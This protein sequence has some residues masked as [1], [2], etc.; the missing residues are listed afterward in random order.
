MS[1]LKVRR[2]KQIE[3]LIRESNIIV[4]GGDSESS[5][6]AGTDDALKAFDSYLDRFIDRAIDPE[7]FK[8][9][10]V[11]NGQRIVLAYLEYCKKRLARITEQLTD[12]IQ[13]GTVSA[14]EI[15][16]LSDRKRNLVK[17]ISVLDDIYSALRQRED[18]EVQTLADEVNL[19]I[20]EVHQLIF[21]SYLQLMEAAGKKNLENLQR[22]Q[23]SEDP[24]EKAE[25]AQDIVVSWNT[26]DEVSADMP[27][28][29][30]EDLDSLR[31]QTYSNIETAIGPER[32]EEIKKGSG[33]NR[34]EV[35]LL[36]RIVQLGYR[37]FTTEEELEAEFSDVRSKINALHGSDSKHVESSPETIKYMTD[38]VNE[39]YSVAKRKLSD[40]SIELNKAKGIRYDFNVKLKLHEVVDLP[41][42]GA[43]IADASKIMKLRKAMSSLLDL[44]LGGQPDAPM[45][46]AGQAWANFGKRLTTIYSKTL[47]TTA[48]AVGKALKGREGEIKGDA[49]SRMFIPS[50][51]TILKEP[52]AQSATFED[53]VAPG[54]SAQVPGSIGGMGNPAAPTPTSIGSGD[55]FNPTKKR[56]TGKKDK[57]VLEFNDFVHQFLK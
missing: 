16:N 28:T 36:E 27:E 1:F 4:R 2:L 8:N 13:R 55:N 41:V 9:E 6:E 21:D 20:K 48:K 23:Q 40:K 47:N 26:I 24:A 7:Y 5:T 33:L 14:T 43:Q 32:F 45:T 35:V 17:K 37:V 18:S 42:T 52:S 15:K 49:L 54:V 53:A 56:G 38:L 30:R 51:D 31:N 22:I 50:P 29:Q 44:L 3:D 12:A 11:K 39:A 25:V 34:Q 46:A 19:K 10:E 57:R